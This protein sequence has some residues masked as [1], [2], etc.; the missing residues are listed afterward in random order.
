MTGPSDL[1]AAGAQA[2]RRDRLPNRRAHESFTFTHA[3]IRY[4][5][6]ICRFDD[7]RLGEIFLNGSKTGTDADTSARDAAIVAS[8]ALQSGVASDTI[9]HALTRNR[10]GSA[11][12]PLGVALDKLAT[13]PEGSQ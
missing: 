2:P 5:A 6:G 3:G 13:D 8:I 9:R 11:S 4:T 7:G 10:D 12:G 1:S